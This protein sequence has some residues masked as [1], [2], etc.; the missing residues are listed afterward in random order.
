M[1]IPNDLAQLRA[2]ALAGLRGRVSPETRPFFFFSD[3]AETFDAGNT[4]WTDRDLLRASG[5]VQAAVR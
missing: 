1:R 5:L 4:R 2:K 3:V